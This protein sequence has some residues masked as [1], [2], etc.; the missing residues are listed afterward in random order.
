MEETATNH[1]TWKRR[2]RKQT[3]GRSQAA[4]DRDTYVHTY[5]ASLMDIANHGNL[6]HRRLFD[7]NPGQLD[8]KSSKP[9]T[10]KDYEQKSVVAVVVVV[11]V[12][13]LAKN[14]SSTLNT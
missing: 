9:T 13:T 12:V 5:R 1:G 14:K 3:G 8:K 4:S 10:V 7:V 2:L 6:L 11:V